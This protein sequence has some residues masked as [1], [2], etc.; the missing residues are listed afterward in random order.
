MRSSVRGCPGGLALPVPDTKEEVVLF[1]FL[2]AEMDHL[3]YQGY[4]GLE[5]N[6]KPDTLGSL[7]WIKEYKVQLA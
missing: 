4:V 1:H 6:P 2:F 7:G 3:G 5:Y